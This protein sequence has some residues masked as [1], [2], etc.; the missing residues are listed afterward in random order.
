MEMCRRLSS[1]TCAAD[2]RT[3]A[4]DCAELGD[5]WVGICPL[6]DCSANDGKIALWPGKD[7]WHCFCCMRGGN[8]TDLARL[9]GYTLAPSTLG[10]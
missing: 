8:T 5:K 7:S 10:R 6:P 2:L 1:R 4:R 3:I 9:A